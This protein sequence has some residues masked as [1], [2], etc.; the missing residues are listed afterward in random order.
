VLVLA[1]QFFLEKLAAGK[2]GS[3]LEYGGGN[4]SF[5]NRSNFIFS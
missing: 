1:R 5:P 2:S 3:Q 4:F